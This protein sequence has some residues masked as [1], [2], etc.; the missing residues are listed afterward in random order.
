MKGNVCSAIQHNFLTRIR[1]SRT[2]DQCN[3]TH[4]NPV[5]YPHVDIDPFGV[6]GLVEKELGKEESNLGCGCGTP[7]HA[8]STAPINGTI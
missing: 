4:R 2:D 1:S 7:T 6:Q 3:D 8:N 5:L